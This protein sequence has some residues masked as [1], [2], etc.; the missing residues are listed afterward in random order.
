MDDCHNL[1][2]LVGAFYLNSFRLHYQLLALLADR[3]LH[4]F[5]AMNVVAGKKKSLRAGPSRLA[6]TFWA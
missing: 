6:F 4:L 3:D 2:P 5:S 1:A